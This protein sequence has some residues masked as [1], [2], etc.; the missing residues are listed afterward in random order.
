MLQW[1]SNFSFKNFKNERFGLYK[2]GFMHSYAGLTCANFNFLPAGLNQ[3]VIRS[4]RSNNF[5]D[6]SAHLSIRSWILQR[7]ARKGK[8]AS[9]FFF[10]YLLL[11]YQFSD[12]MWGN[13]IFSYYQLER[14]VASLFSSTEILLLLIRRVSV[15]EYM[16]MNSLRETWKYK[17]SSS[18]LN[19]SPLQN[20]LT[21]LCSHSFDWKSIE[22]WCQRCGS[23]WMLGE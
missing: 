11:H 2:V 12:V 16:K 13:T 1:T 21:D 23:S 4:F 20:K 5:V 7:S 14:L 6:W 19:E 22:Q 8:D 3:L 18:I 10:T 9:M 17:M 15:G